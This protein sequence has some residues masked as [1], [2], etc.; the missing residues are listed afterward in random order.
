MRSKELIAHTAGFLLGVSH[1][2]K[3]D[4]V[5]KT[6]VSEDLEKASKWL[7]DYLNEKGYD[8]YKER[9]ENEDG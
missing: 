8:L 1:R 3:Q 4:N 9:K 2:L 6:K 7:T 5:D